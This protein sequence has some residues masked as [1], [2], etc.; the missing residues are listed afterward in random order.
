MAEAMGELR[1]QLGP[2]AIIVST[3]RGRRGQGV[4]I[5]AAIERAADQ[6]DAGEAP[7]GSAASPDHPIAQALAY[8]G[9]PGALAGRLCGAVAGHDDGDLA[10]VLAE[11]LGQCFGF[12]PLDQP[13][14]RPLMLVGPPGAGKTVTTAKLAARAAMAG[15]PVK[16]VTIDTIRAGGVDQLSAFTKVLEVPLT[17]A[18]SPEELGR[19]LNGERQG[20]ATF[21]D[22]PGTN[23]FDPRE[24]G[25]LKDFTQTL[26]IELVLVL[27]AGADASEA[28][29]LAEAFSTLGL[30][31]LI[32]TRLDVSRRLGSLLAAADAAHLTL[33]EASATPFVGQGLTRLDPVALARLLMGD[34]TLPHIRSACD[35]AAP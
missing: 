1:A 8:H 24:F 18:D 7:F 3:S 6:D 5:S 12:A 31:R 17:A 35:R 29:E 9:V 2:D 28:A 27:A 14:P 15:D 16:V 19:A 33:S 10:R 23:V 34:P 20:A 32:V 11:A 21:I 4:R 26:D 22:T 25:D 13:P 30:R